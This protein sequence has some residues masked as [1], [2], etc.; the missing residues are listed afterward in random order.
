MESSIQ[1]NTPITLWQAAK[2]V[3]LYLVLLMAVEMIGIL[4]QPDTHNLWLSLALQAAGNALFFVLLFR[5]TRLSIRPLYG[6]TLPAIGLAILGC[7]FCV[8]INALAVSPILSLFSQESEAQYIQ[9]MNAYVENPVAGV[10]LICLIAPVS[11][12]LLLRGFVLGGL[13]KRYGA[14][15]ALFLSAAL[16]SLMHLNLLQA[17]SVLSVGLV[18]GHLYIHTGSLLACTL[19]HVLYNGIAYLSLLLV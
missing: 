16:F 4:L 2:W 7:L 5:R 13:S 11:E 8:V 14:L 18:L 6:A 19:M 1:N 12:E 10:L 9:S 15:P 3:M 17:L